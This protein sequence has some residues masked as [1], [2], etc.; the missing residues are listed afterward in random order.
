[1]E[2]D[3]NQIVKEDYIK[4]NFDMWKER[5]QFEDYYD[6][7]IKLLFQLQWELLYSSEIY[8][9]NR[10]EQLEMILRIHGSLP[11][12]FFNKK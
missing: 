11:Q 7:Q 2:T 9:Q 8:S 5:Y 6:F 4:I 3:T 1:M 10:R 12:D